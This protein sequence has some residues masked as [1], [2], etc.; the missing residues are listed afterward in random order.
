MSGVQNLKGKYWKLNHWNLTKVTKNRDMGQWSASKKTPNNVLNIIFESIQGI[1]WFFLT[2]S[3]IY[4]TFFKNLVPPV[5]LKD[6][7]PTPHFTNLSSQQ[8]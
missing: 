5:L 1:S 7:R 6:A 2:S 4:Y 8:P 3:N